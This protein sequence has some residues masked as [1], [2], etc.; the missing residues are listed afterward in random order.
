MSFT[1]LKF[2]P[3]TSLSRVQREILVL[4]LDDAVGLWEAADIV[5]DF[6]GLEGDPEG[7]SDR[8]VA[9]ITSL[10]EEE[11]MVYGALRTGGAFRAFEGEPSEAAAAIQTG[12]RGLGHDPSL[13]DVGWLQLTEQGK[14][15]ALGIKAG[16]TPG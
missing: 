12:W 7:L 9:A 13:G 10:L 3:M 16:G 8:T 15:V 5:R 4:G 14:E 2:I 1:K 11:L 6:E